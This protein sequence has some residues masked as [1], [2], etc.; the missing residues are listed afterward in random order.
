[1][2]VE[3]PVAAQLPLSSPSVSESLPSKAEITN[4]FS[5]QLYIY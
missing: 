4:D 2:G 5:A 3:S 1:M